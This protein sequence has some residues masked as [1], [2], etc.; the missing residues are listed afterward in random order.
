MTWLSRLLSQRPGLQRPADHY[1]RIRQGR[2]RRR[3]AN[4]ETLEGR[5][6]LSNVVTSCARNPTTGAITLIIQGDTGNDT[7]TVSENASGTAT[8]TGTARTLINAT[9]LPYTTTQAIS[10]IT[11]SLPGTNNNTDQVVLTG[12]GKSIA[13]IVNS[14]SVTVTGTPALTLIVD[15][16]DN[17]GPLTVTD[18]S[19][20]IAGGAL[21]A[22][23][24]NSHF[25]ALT[26]YET[27][28]SPTSVEL[29]NNSVPGAVSVTEGVANG[30]VITLDKG[31]TFGSTVLAQGVGPTVTKAYGNGDSI[32]VTSAAVRNLT[33]TQTDG[34]N[35]FIHV[36]KV[37]VSLT[38]FGVIAQQGDGAIDV[39]AIN[40]VTAFGRG[41]IPAVIP[42][43]VTSQVDGGGDVVMVSNIVLPGNISMS[44]GNG[45]GDLAELF[46]STAGWT[47]QAGP[48]VQ[49]YEGVAS[50]TQGSGYNDMVDLDL[51]NSLNNLNITQ[52]DSISTPG[53]VPGL[54]DEIDIEATNV[55]SDLA[56]VQ[57]DSSAVGNNV[58]TIG[59]STQV[60]VGGWTSITQGGAINTVML[61]GADDPSGIDFESGY[62]DI[63]TGA[64]GGGFVS[65][66]NTTVDNGSYFGFPYVI[67]GGGTGNVYYDAGGNSPSPL[68]Y[69]S[70]Y[71]G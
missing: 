6:L 33:M 66:A 19:S 22:I 26:I 48:Y 13:T 45:D 62:L 65:A 41:Q 52:G 67:D 14:V 34:K 2:R 18:G 44:Q 63:Y 25:T 7:F 12:P 20:T 36:N 35:V 28:G 39:I 11:V 71:S 8:I 23:V 64:G 40:A 21:H 53:C 60:L 17:S 29:G 54:G 15:N 61:G 5:T 30:D 1:H 9:H 32:G 42:G 37:A 55:V 58:V 69:S 68:P 50:L 51:G 38:S 46:G 56:I 43:I 24:D 10:N 70:N 59:G 57:G 49:D 47:V 4:L 27:G 3:M 31:D 16:V